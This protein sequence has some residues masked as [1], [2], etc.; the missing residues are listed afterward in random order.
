MKADIVCD[1][2]R[3]RCY[4]KTS[5]VGIRIKHVLRGQRSGHAQEKDRPAQTGACSGRQE[6]IRVTAEAKRHTAD[7]RWVISRMHEDWGGWGETS[8]GACLRSDAQ[9][10]SNIQRGMVLCVPQSCALEHGRE[11][12]KMKATKKRGRR[13]PPPATRLRF[14]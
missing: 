10:S 14:V 4:N 13:A 1:T 8:G 11:K 5:C 9:G 7:P 12:M 2:T 6:D 3:L